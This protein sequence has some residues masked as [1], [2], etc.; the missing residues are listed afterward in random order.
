MAGILLAMLLIW[1][2]FECSL[3]NWEDM[4]SKQESDLLSARIR[5]ARLKA[6]LPPEPD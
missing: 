2:V 5:L 3:L 6:G 1:I 4:H